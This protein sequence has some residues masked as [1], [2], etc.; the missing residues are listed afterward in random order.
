MHLLNSILNVIEKDK[1]HGFKKMSNGTLLIRRMTEIREDY[2]MHR[3]FHSLSEQEI[4]SFEKDSNLKF[5]DVY[6][7]FLKECNGI[8]LYGGLVYIY[9]K[10]YLKK[11]MSREE[12]M[13][14]PYDLIEENEDP[15][16]DIPENLFYFGGTPKTIFS[17]DRDNQVLEMRRKSGKVLKK[18]NNV[19]YWLSEMLLKR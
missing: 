19:E 18:W 17:L 5:P 11:G 6:K 15:P 7:D 4:N 9:G 10:A 2:W 12:Q 16:C 13:F 14:Q 1:I 3:I 8:F